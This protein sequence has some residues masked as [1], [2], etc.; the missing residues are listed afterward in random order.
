MRGR[1]RLF[2]GIFDEIV[3]SVRF[4]ELPPVPEDPVG[5]SNIVWDSRDQPGDG[6]YAIVFL[7]LIEAAEQGGA[8]SPG[9]TL[10]IET[11][12]GTAGRGLAYIAGRL[13]YAVRI[14]MPDPVHVHRREALERMLPERSQLVL[15]PQELYVAGTVKALRKYLVESAHEPHKD[16]EPFAL[17][18]SRDLRSIAAFEELLEISWRRSALRLPKALSKAVAALG[19]GTFSTAFMRFARRLTQGASRIGVEPRKAPSVWVKKYGVEAYRQKFGADPEYSVHQMPGAGG[20]NV[21]FP[22]L[23]PDDLDD[24]CLVGDDMMVRYRE[25]LERTGLSAGNSSAAC[26]LASFMCGDN[27]AGRPNVR[28]TPLYEHGEL[29]ND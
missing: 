2:A 25:L 5:G 9:R 22:F 7:R 13:G 19:N 20:W 3:E 4:Y 27:T 16:L 17:N 26:L 10:L 6:H 24:V 14:F 29:Y 18:H 28:L 12:T 11:T 15:T 21:T 1:H 23:S 8:I